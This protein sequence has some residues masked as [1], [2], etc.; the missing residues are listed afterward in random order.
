[1]THRGDVSIVTIEAVAKESYHENG[2]VNEIK[3]K[4]GRVVVEAKAEVGSILVTAEETNKSDVKIVVNDSATLGAIGAKN[5]DISKESGIITGADKT[6][7]VTGAT[8]ESAFAGGFGTEK[9]PYLIADLQGFKNISSNS[10][11][12]FKMIAD[13]DLGVLTKD[14]LSSF[15]GTFDGNGHVLTVKSTTGAK[16]VIAKA[17]NATF[18]NL[19]INTQNVSFV[20]SGHGLTY[21]DNVDISGEYAT[22]GSNNESAYIYW[23]FGSELRFE[24]CDAS[25]NLKGDGWQAIF[26]GG[27]VDTT[28]N[29]NVIFKNLTYSGHSVSKKV[30]M[31]AG[32]GSQWLSDDSRKEK[33]RL[34]VENCVNKGTIIS[35][36]SS[37]VGTLF[38]SNNAYTV[39]A[40][41]LSNQEGGSCVKLAKLTD[42]TVTLNDNK[43]TFNVTNSRV[44]KIVVKAYTRVDM[45]SK[46]DKNITGN[47][48][49]YVLVKEYSDFSNLTLEAKFAAMTEKDHAY[50]IYDSEIVNLNPN[51][52]NY[53]NTIAGT[54][55]T[56]KVTYDIF[57]YGADGS[58]IG[59]DSIEVKPY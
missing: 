44:G 40:A 29:V 8:G 28:E 53:T 33:L 1:M 26:L 51:N 49:Y 35:T 30:A 27:Y 15:R 14:L 3:L 50:N 43:I 52:A 17:T 57:F 31:L 38:C 11:K 25:Y 56:A 41:Q 7:V 32:N 16:S 22:A 59:Y 9:A 45:A 10:G 24:N 47:G 42:S 55:G 36:D 34:T 21:F 6:T 23:F 48:N 4:D 20:A 12:Y 37:S 2:K 54:D 5:F 13:V 46:T 58:I 18:K 19:K 39:D